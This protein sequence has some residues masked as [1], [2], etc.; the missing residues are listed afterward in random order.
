MIIDFHTHTFPDKI[1]DKAIASLVKKGGIQPYRSGTVASLKETME[2]SSVD[3][4]VV[5][6]VATHPKQETT[7]NRV[8]AELNG[9]NNLFFAGGIHPDCDDVESTL[10]FIKESGL[11]GIKLHPDY[12]GAHFDDPRYINIMKKAF[13][14]GLY[15]VAHAGLDVA[16]PDH[17]HCTPDMILNA[18][19]QFG[20]LADGKLILAHLGGFMLADEV[21]EKLIGLPVYMDT[22]VAL[23]YYP[24]KC[25]EII[26]RHGADRILFGSDS[27]WA[28][29]AEFVKII[30]SYGFSKEDEEKIF[31]QNASK[32]LF[33]N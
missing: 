29:Q 15:V 7:I 6:P 26:I 11:F 24:E 20:G 22:A 33:G 25:R 10:D 2:Q 13:K 19:S 18:L 1:A 5:L 28:D 32:I 27:P 31:Y 12:Q 21:L 4:S 30:K 17:I 8:S 3:Y 16:Y 23:S 9:K 14:R